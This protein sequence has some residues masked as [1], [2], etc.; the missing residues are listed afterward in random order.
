MAG[1]RPPFPFIVACGRSGTTLV[2]AMLNAHPEMAIPPEAHFLV[3]GGREVP[4]RDG[5]IDIEH[6]TSRWERHP[7]FALW[8]LSPDRLREA[9]SRARPATYPDA[10]RALYALYAEEREKPRYGDKTPKHVLSLPYLA[11]AFPEARFIHL[12]RDGR[13][14]TC[15]FIARGI[16]P[17]DAVEGAIRWKR[18]VVRGRRDGA[19]LGRGRYLEVRYEDFV[20]DPEGNLRRICDFIDLPWD[21]SMLEYRAGL[22]R[23]LPE[24]HLRDL[25]ENVYRPPTEGLR[26]WR[27]EM[28]PEE[29]AVFEALAGDLLSELGYE[30]TVPRPPPRLRL[31]ARRR[32]ALV[33]AERARRKALR[34]AGRSSGGSTGE[35]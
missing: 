8:E 14:V 35:D 23:M 30:R 34:I 10:A 32:W 12:L 27:R 22:D 11:D 4:I 33:K 15:S 18:T 26:D 2:Q 3:P 20:A 9:L 24:G 13:D 7:Y 31:E 5:A 28:T 29:V 1:S 16:G 25:H 21:G 19:R 6:V 17:R